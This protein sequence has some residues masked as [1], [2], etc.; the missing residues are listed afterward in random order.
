[1]HGNNGIYCDKEIKQE[2]IDNIYRIEYMVTSNWIMGYTREIWVV[3][4]DDICSEE[5]PKRSLYIGRPLVPEY[6]RFEDNP[7]EHDKKIPSEETIFC[8]HFRSIHYWEVLDRLE[9]WNWMNL[10]PKLVVTDGLIMD[11]AFF[12]KD[13]DGND[14]VCRYQIAENEIADEMTEI[15]DRFFDTMKITEVERVTV[16][17]EMMNKSDDLLPGG[18]ENKDS[19]E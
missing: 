2:E 8:N 1:M 17:E 12:T 19:Q 9:V 14:K 3:D 4:F 7:A 16:N 11:V 5:Y 15:F 6:R 18:Y 13:S 10:K